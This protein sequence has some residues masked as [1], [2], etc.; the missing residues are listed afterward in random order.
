MGKEQKQQ[1]PEEQ[2][3]FDLDTRFPFIFKLS[4]QAEEAY[5]SWARKRK[6]EL[7]AA[8]QAIETSTRTY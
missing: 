2:V 4:E 1:E 7:R 5:A 3:A 8:F 6:E